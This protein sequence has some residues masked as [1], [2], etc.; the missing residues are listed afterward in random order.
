[1]ADWIKIVEV[2]N[3]K[4]INELLLEVDNGEASSVALDN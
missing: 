2:K 3:Q 1:L 4:F